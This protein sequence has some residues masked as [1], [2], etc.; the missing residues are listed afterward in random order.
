MRVRNEMR[1]LRGVMREEDQSRGVKTR[2]EILK[3]T[4]LSLSLSAV[5]NGSEVK[6]M[7]FHLII[8]LN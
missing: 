4:F 3:E 2:A 6:I 8:T 5:F 7:P 1:E